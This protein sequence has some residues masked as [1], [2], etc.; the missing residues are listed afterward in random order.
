MKHIC[1]VCKGSGKIDIKVEIPRNVKR[2]IAITMRQNG[3]TIRQIMIAL[4]LKNPGNV[5][6][7]LK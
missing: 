1:P 7:L 2:D 6:H 3:F 5:T 4:E